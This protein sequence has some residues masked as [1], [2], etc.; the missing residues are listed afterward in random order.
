MQCALSQ[1]FFEG[2]AK[3]K[4]KIHDI[5]GIEGTIM[6]TTIEAEIDTDGLVRLLEPVKVKKKRRAILTLLE[7]EKG[8]RNEI[9]EEDAKTAEKRFAKWIGS[10]DSGNPNSADN[11]L[12]DV[13]LAWE[14]RATHD[15]ER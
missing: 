7:D 8:E 1:T 3:V 6:L 4:T 5:I 14:Y 2:E 15:D 9:N 10:V 13:D 12:I 11:E